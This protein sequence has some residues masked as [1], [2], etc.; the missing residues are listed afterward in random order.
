MLWVL[1]AL[2]SAFGWATADVF[3]KKASNVDDYI[4]MLSRFL[5]GVPF[6]VVFLFFIPIPK[7]DG[8]FWTLLSLAIS[9]ETAVWILYI[10]AI[11][12]SPLSL[13][14]PFLSL[15]PVFLVFT[16]FIILGEIPTPIGFF[17]IL[18]IAFG[19]YVL[20]FKNLGKGILDPFKS[21]FKK[22]GIVYM[23][24]AAFLF[25]ILANLFKIL[26]QKSSA[27]FLAAIYFP[28]MVIPFLLIAFLKSRKNLVQLKSNFKSLFPIGLFFALMIIFN[29]LAIRLVIVPY[30]ISIKRTSSIFSVLY[31][32]FLF[33]EK[34]IK[35]RF[36]GTII[37]L[38]GTGLIIL[39]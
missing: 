7:L 37:M 38:I 27:M 33:K 19:A 29:N 3:T 18:M 1:Y 14:V 20:N 11:K 4:L 5:F 30:M 16:S 13:V 39:F 2:L 25:S 21:I 10:K 17:G 15:T 24:I 6:V 32:Y 22:R 28:L 12:N 31:G 36:V 34:N 26:I 35:A 23:I 9:L 8:S